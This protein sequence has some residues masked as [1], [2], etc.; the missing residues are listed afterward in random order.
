MF[1]KEDK[2]IWSFGRR[3]GRFGLWGREEVG[4]MFEKEQREVLLLGKRRG[5][6]CVW[7][8]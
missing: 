8:K 2:V 5:R 1:G 6:V 4:L 3:S 7:V